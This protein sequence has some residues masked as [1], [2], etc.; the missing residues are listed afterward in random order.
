MSENSC[1]IKLDIPLRVVNQ[2]QKE[3]TKNY[4]ISGVINCNQNNEVL[5]VSTTKGNKD[6][7]HTKNHVIN[8]H[9]HPISAYIAGNTVWGWPSG[10]DI[11]ETIKFTLAGNKA[12]IVFSVEGLYIIQVNSCKIK[13]LINK[14]N[15]TER[16]V[17]IFI[18]EEYFKC[19]HNF[20]CIDEI[21]KLKHEIL[22]ESYIDYINNF[23]LEKLI[24]IKR[25]ENNF[26]VIPSFGFPV[27]KGSTISSNTIKEY[28]S[29]SEL[30]D[31]VIIDQHGTETKNNTIKKISQV[32]TIF[33]T[34]IKKLDVNCN[35]NWNNT[36][37][38]SWFYVNFFPT[39][40]YT[41][42]EYLI[43]GH[44]RNPKN[45]DLKYLNVVNT[46]YIKIFSNTTDGCT[47]QQISK[48]N[49]FSIH[50]SHN[51]NNLTFGELR[52]TPEER[53]VI[54][55][56]FFMNPNDNII[57][58]TKKANEFRII[59]KL[60]MGTITQAEVNSELSSLFNKTSRRIS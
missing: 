13:K 52:I 30:S 23:E 36:K 25:G 41:N 22:P 4:E 3:L 26:G 31:L 29:K 2:I 43:N 58:L 53:Y 19:T 24:R 9:T 6:S 32:V 21:G 37:K 20:R 33:D 17:L 56:V 42:K 12:H 14:L 15:S 5:S 55:Y 16:G 44:Y 46:P 28:I 48:I 51:Q 39:E 57:L 11:R 27:I 8:F 1:N 35:N 54:L 7:V 34:I 45:S 60:K 47:I 38:N 49:K 40:Y 10:E 18:I 59:N 50:N